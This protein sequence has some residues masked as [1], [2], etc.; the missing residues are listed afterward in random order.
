MRCD[1]QEFLSRLIEKIDEGLKGSS[2]NYLWNNIFGGTTLQQ[3]RCTNQDCGN[4]SERKENINYLSLD[5]KNC[6][7]IQKC[8]DKFIAEEKIEDYH[9]EKCDKKITNIKNVLIDKIPNILIIHLQRI[10]FS[11]DTFN[12]EKINDYIYFEKT[13]NI[14]NYTLNKNND[15]MPSDYFEYELQGVLIY[16]G[17]SQFGHYYS[18]IYSDEEDITGKWYKFNEASITQINCDMMTNNA[19]GNNARQEYG[20]SAYMLIYQKKD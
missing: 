6:D 9:C 7:N 11:Y 18:I 4:I 19:F 5:I 12:M 16:S 17:T 3:V 20:S 2:Q 15:D 1:A 13:I 14:K 10:A 8:L